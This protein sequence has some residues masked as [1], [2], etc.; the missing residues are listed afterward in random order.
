MEYVEAY[1]RK[2][3][4][5]AALRIGKAALRANGHVLKHVDDNE[6]YGAFVF[7]GWLEEAK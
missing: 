4:F 2:G 7:D 5:D 1:D 6:L 3:A